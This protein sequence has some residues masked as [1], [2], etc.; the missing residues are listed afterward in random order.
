[1]GTG[2]KN[3]HGVDAVNMAVERAGLVQRKQLPGGGRKGSSPLI[4]DLRTITAPH[5]EFSFELTPGWWRSE[6]PDD[7]ILGLDGPV[8]VS[9]TLARLGTK[10]VL[11]GRVS[12]RLKVPC[13]RC[14]ETYSLP[15]DAS[16]RLFLVLPP[17]GE[18]AEEVELTEEDLATDYITTNEIDLAEL[19][20]EQIYLSL[21][22]KLLCR[23]DCRGICPR[24]G[25]NL[26]EAACRC[27][28]D[29]TNPAFA[30]LKTLKIQGD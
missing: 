7:P 12:G 8:S 23:E 27:K 17:A 19:V 16:F 24:C 15:V 26:N 25:V 21:P 20:R 28:E 29:R 6:G 13:D 10:F 1:M 30:K 14:L 5:R 4:I 3:P 9:A 18:D 2:W 11:E 22:M